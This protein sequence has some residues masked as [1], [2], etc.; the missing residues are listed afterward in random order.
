[1]YR[2]KL[3]FHTRGQAGRAARSGTQGHGCPRR[4]DARH[5]GVEGG[6]EAGGARQEGK[7]CDLSRAPEQSKALS[8]S[9]RVRIIAETLHRQLGADLFEVRLAKPYRPDY[10]QHVARAKHERDS[11]YAPPLAARVDDMAR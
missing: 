2:L 9:V 5:Q 3:A 11:G 4:Q 1:M 6:R 10:E 8:T 7:A